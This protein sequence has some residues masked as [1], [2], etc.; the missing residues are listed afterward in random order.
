MITFKP[1]VRN[2]RADDFAAIYIRV[3]KDRETD[4]IKTNY[5]AKRAQL[6]GKNLKDYSLIAPKCRL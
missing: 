4:Y 1:V 5:I 3:T 6:S 2:V